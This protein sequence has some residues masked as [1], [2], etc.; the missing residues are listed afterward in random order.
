MT[1][2]RKTTTIMRIRATMP[3]SQE[4]LLV[5]R[6]REMATT[7]DVRVVVNR[8]TVEVSVTARRKAA[9]QHSERVNIK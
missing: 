1:L 5:L 3:C 9:T 7:I 2:R 4:R 8:N 6:K